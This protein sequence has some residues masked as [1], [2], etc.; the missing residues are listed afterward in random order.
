MDMDNEQRKG[1]QEPKCRL[2]NINRRNLFGG[3]CIA[4]WSGALQ[5]YTREQIFS[6]ATQEIYRCYVALRSSQKFLNL[7]SM[8]RPTHSLIQK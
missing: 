8:K 6:F 2:K 4:G 7:L 1:E 3:E 5:H